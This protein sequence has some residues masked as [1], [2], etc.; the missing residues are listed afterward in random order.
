MN[1]CTVCTYNADP[2]NTLFLRPEISKTALL[3]RKTLENGGMIGKS[4]VGKAWSLRKPEVFRSVIFICYRGCRPNI[5]S[6]QLQAVSKARA[7]CRYI[8]VGEMQGFSI[9]TGNFGTKDTT[10]ISKNTQRIVKS[11]RDAGQSLLTPDF[12]PFTTNRAAIVLSGCHSLKVFAGTVRVTPA[13][14]EPRALCEALFIAPAAF[15]RLSFYGRFLHTWNNPSEA[16][17]TVL[18]FGL[19]LRWFCKE[20]QRHISAAAGTPR[21]KRLFWAVTVSFF[22]PATA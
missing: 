8:S 19:C 1:M 12:A 20:K 16:A 14:E 17:I 2:E 4:T 6:I 21:R 5:P 11:I 15:F 18:F 22:V 7:V 13:Y 10:L 3:R 9:A